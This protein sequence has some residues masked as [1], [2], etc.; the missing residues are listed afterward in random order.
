M[1][2]LGVTVAIWR[3]PFARGGAGKRLLFSAGRYAMIQA[4][5]VP[6]PVRSAAN[7]LE[8]AISFQP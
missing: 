8:I 6:V 5:V 1:T 2:L 7:I 4:P 3:K